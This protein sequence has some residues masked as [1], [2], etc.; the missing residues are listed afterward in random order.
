MEPP[1]P[2]AGL[3]PGREGGASRIR[4]QRLPLSN[5]GGLDD[6]AHSS[7]PVHRPVVCFPL[8]L[9]LRQQV[10]CRGHS[11]W[12]RSEI[13][14]KLGR[15]V[16]FAQGGGEGTGREGD[17]NARAHGRQ[18]RGEKEKRRTWTSARV[19]WERRKP[20]PFPFIDK[21]GS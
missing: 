11:G 1:K 2:K 8:L 4:A 10:V 5:D 15:I 20:L 6:V 17:L 12:H 21:G 19:P 16:E 9:L 18:R 3:T 13:D 7:F 14:V